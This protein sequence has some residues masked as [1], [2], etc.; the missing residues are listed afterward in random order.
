MRFPTFPQ[1]LRL[2]TIN[3]YEIRILRARSISSIVAPSG[4]VTAKIK[5]RMSQRSLMAKSSW[6]S[7]GI[8][9]PCIDPPL[10]RHFVELWVG[11]VRNG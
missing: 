3:T 7:R 10:N 5:K 6:V 11:S 1:P 8:Y 9:Y 2:R 4:R